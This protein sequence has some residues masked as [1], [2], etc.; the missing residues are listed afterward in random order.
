MLMEMR[1]P[2][3]TC[4]VNCAHP[5]DTLAHMVNWRC[6][7]QFVSLIAGPRAWRWRAILLS[8]G[9]N[10]LIDAAA[11]LPRDKYGMAIPPEHRILLSKSEWGTAG[12][13][14]RYISEEGWALFKSHLAPQ[15]DLLMELLSSP[16]SQNNGIPVFVHLYDY[17]MP[18]NAPAATVPIRMGPWLY[19]SMMAYEIP[20]SDWEVV[21]RVLIDRLADIIKE[22]ADRYP[23]M[24]V[25]DA[26]GTLTVA[27]AGTTGPDGDWENE[28][29]PTNSGY[30]RLADK[31]A[32]EVLANSPTV[33]LIAEPG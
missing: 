17:P 30:R 9:G 2:E 13:D 5:G 19:P 11:V 6:D 23:V 12:N 26:R 21:T 18:R 10:D 28:I 24:H 14:E 1:L 22:A 3:Q 16:D 8:A 33:N 15:F 32:T 31:Y 4:I 27:M 29:H 20:E 7:P 25:V